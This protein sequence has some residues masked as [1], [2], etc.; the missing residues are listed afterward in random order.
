SV[1]KTMSLEAQIGQL[2][3]V[4]AEST[5]DER[6]EK[7]LTA[8]IQELGIGGVL[9]L[10]TTPSALAR[11][12]LS[13][14]QASVVPLFIAIDG[15]N[16]LSFRLDS[17][18]QYPHAMALGALQHDS[19]IYRMGREIGKQCK[20]LGIQ[21]NFAPVADVNSNP[22]NPIINYRSF[23]ENPALVAR[24][25]FLLAKGMQDE[26]VLVSVKHF[27]GHGDTGYD[28]HHTLPVNKKS[29]GELKQEEFIP[30]EYNISGGV[31]GIMSAHIAYS[32]IDPSNRPATLSPFM[33]TE[34][35]KDSLGFSG[36]VFSD[37]M[38]M[39]GITL[40]YN[41][42][43]AAVQAFKAGV[44]V[45]EFILDP[46]RVI[47]AVVAAVKRGDL[48]ADDIAGKC[49]K[50]LMAKHWS[51]LNQPIAV[52][53]NQLHARLNQPGWQLT[54]RQLQEQALTVLQNNQ[55]ILPL[56]RLDTLR[57]ATLSIGADSETA[58]QHQLD[59]YMAMEHFFLPLNASD[60]MIELVLKSLKRFNLVI[61]GVHGTHLYPAR[62]YGV[63][64]MHQKVSKRLFQELPTI[65]VF[66][67]NPYALVH[68]EGVE[69]AKAMVLTYSSSQT[70]QEVSAQMIF[71]AIGANGTLPVSIPGLFP[72]GHG[73][74]IKP[75][76]RLKYTLPEE[77]GFNGY[78]LK[79]TIDSMVSMAIAKKMIPGCQIL[80]ASKGKVIFR[81][82]Y[83]HFRFEASPDV[84]NESL[85]DWASI[86]KIAGTLPLLMKMTEN[87]QLELDQPFANYWES[88]KGTDK[89]SITLR[90]ILAHQA[91]FRPWLPI[92]SRTIAQRAHLRDSLI[93][94]RPSEAFP[95]R[96]SNHCYASG[97]MK[98]Y[99]FDQ[100]TSR[101]LSAKR[102]YAYSDIGFLMFPDLITKLK[103]SNF[104]F[105]VESEF[106]SPLGATGIKYNPYRYYP[107]SMI[108]PTEHDDFMRRE[109]VHG[110]VHDE[111]AALLGGVSG[112]AGLFGSSN[113]LAKIMQF[114][115]QNGQ[116]GDFHYLRPE[117]VKEYTRVQFPGSENRRGLGF[118]KPY[119][120]N[121]RRKGLDTFPAQFASAASFGH[122]GYTGTFAWAD[123]K[124]Q[125]LFIFLSN[126]VYPTRDNRRLILLNIRPLIHQE[127]Y[128]C[129]NT[130]KTEIY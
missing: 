130:F 93:R 67:S 79:S 126:R 13:F 90:E 1:M 48:S 116:Y 4:T 88:F 45:I 30:F 36:L 61:A 74:V 70:A 102:T 38:N 80:V 118:D 81:K 73:V 23:G 75:I 7:Q 6:R 86:T 127:V 35:L 107:K 56:Q 18:V 46:E 76:G 31:N 55:S 97:E 94:A 129:A 15:E 8:W 53:L 64:S 106:L 5:D 43:E 28:S 71:G 9:F 22:L 50:V 110:Y 78:L 69:N 49:R 58:F 60:Q 32:G 54:A 119:A 44:D 72:S 63:T 47:R 16:G 113:E 108:V 104:E 41:E 68:F 111:A 37:G 92:P 34:V 115:L 122:T 17:V 99:F 77:A 82:A 24:K 85:Y 11:K 100:F 19:L 91:G 29:Y 105:L 84:S 83:G 12:A 112:N 26:K 96:V 20:T 39:K 125:L 33:M 89:S 98:A 128:R 40:L 123:P 62:K 59:D 14:Q 95:V 109:L 25:S 3:M 42:S 65:M 101:E 87:K 120:D 114:Y 52:P 2:I 121:A 10:K 117:T 103:G 124:N 51:G 57:V 21:L 27:P 66:F